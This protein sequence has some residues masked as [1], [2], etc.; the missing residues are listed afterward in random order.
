MILLLGVLAVGLSGCGGT[1]TYSWPGLAVSGE[2][3]FLAFNQYI[4]AINI[5]DG[6]QIWKYPEA[7]DSTLMFYSNPWM[8]SKGNL[9]AGSY[10]GSVVF[11]N[12]QTGKLI[13]KF[14]GGKTKIYGPVLETS[15][16]L[17]ISSE[18]GNLHF[19]NPADGTPQ[20]T[21]KMG[22]SSWGMMAADAQRIYI[23]T[24]E[25]WVY[26]L[27]ASTG[28]S[29]WSYDTGTSI[30][31]GVTLAGDKLLVGTFG[32]TVVVLEAATGKELKQLDADGWVWGAPTVNG[33]V[34]Y[35]ADLAGS[36]RAVSLAD[37]KDIWPPIKLGKPITTKI[38]LYQD[39]LLVG[40]DDGKVYALSTTDGTQKWVA[41][42]EVGVHGAMVISGDRLLVTLGSGTSPL[43]AV[44]LV[45]GSI[46][47]K[48]EGVK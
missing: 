33:D 21:I 45:N 19:L 16:S 26:A 30:A 11:L 20:R 48:F 44:S 25:H 1:Q 6:T 37:W 42:F 41:T 23:A 29:L 7:A 32:K 15:D 35:Y 3:A 5:K 4:A 14:D 12:A 40:T 17:I 22:G 10:N 8:D 27:N 47:W 31:G 39:M 34:A 13:W 28:A 43:A 2:T 46:I 18:D 9:A 38:V 36:V 24:L